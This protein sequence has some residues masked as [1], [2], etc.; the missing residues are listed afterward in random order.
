MAAMLMEQM[1]LTIIIR[2]LKERLQLIILMK[3]DMRLKKTQIQ[4]VMWEIIIPQL[5]NQQ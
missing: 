5:L 4:R 3:T 2:F 1:K